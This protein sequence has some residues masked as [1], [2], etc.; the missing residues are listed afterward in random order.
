LQAIENHKNTGA[1]AKPMLSF[2]Q[3]K[4]FLGAAELVGLYIVMV[5]GTKILPQRLCFT[6]WKLWMRA[7]LMLWSAVLFSGLWTYDVW[8]IA[9]VS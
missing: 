8:Y 1:A 4:G 7:E 2:A 5:A 6:G 9:P 3:M